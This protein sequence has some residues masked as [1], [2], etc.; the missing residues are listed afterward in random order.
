MAESGGV[1]TPVQHACEHILSGPGIGV[2][3]AV[4]PAF[5]A[6]LGP[7][8]QK[9]ELTLVPGADGH[10]VGS[11][12]FDASVAGKYAVYMS[13]DV[14]LRVSD[15][16]GVE[17]VVREGR[18]EASD[19]AELVS[20]RTVSLGVGPHMLTWGPANV[21]GVTVVVEPDAAD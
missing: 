18:P 8:H 3:A 12:W 10:Y 15:P 20:K 11:A 1:E 6:R 13:A 19:C 9:I 2:Q 21:A 5:A 7:P 16:A 17:L 4:D 14:D